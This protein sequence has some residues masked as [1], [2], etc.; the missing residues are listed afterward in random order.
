MNTELAVDRK[1]IALLA[2]L[3]LP[4][5]SECCGS[6]IVFKYVEEHETDDG[7]VDTNHEIVAN[8]T[9]VHFVAD[10]EMLT[11]SISLYADEDGIRIAGLTY[12][13]KKWNLQYID[14]DCDSVE[15][16][17]TVT[18]VRAN[19]PDAEP[20]ASRQVSAPVPV[21]VS[22]SSSGAI[23]PTE[24]YEGKIMRAELV[25]A[26]VVFQ[27]FASSYGP[28]RYWKNNG[29]VSIGVE[30]SETELTGWKETYSSAN[31]VGKKDLVVIV[32]I[33]K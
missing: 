19:N 2:Q 12:S 26:G 21:I 5:V 9:A 17:L 20:V 3:G 32:E 28:K 30:P 22:S 23:E 25:P 1:L 4:G 6:T 13:D 10:L 7:Y 11:F 14:D 24:I 16:K 8:I 27:T 18:S 29:G 31:E 15:G 33:L